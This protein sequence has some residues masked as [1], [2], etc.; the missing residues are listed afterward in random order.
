[1]G[2]DL[3]DDPSRP[4]D[5]QSG[6][7][8]SCFINGGPGSPGVGVTSDDQTE[9]FG[10]LDRMCAYRGLPNYATADTPHFPTCARAG[11]GCALYAGKAAAL[12]AGIEKCFCGIIVREYG[13]P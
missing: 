5:L 12:E 6:D 10:L 2:V 7:T 11:D 4:H 3:P 9:Y 13:A 8:C 1:M